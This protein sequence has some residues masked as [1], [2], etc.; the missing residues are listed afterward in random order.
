[1][2][3]L[4]L[5]CAG[6]LTQVA[7]RLPSGQ[8]FEFVEEASQGHGTQA[9]PLIRHAL[10]QAGI[11]LDELK[12]L[13]VGRGPGS[14]NGVRVALTTMKGLAFAL[15]VPLIAA[16]RL[17]ALAASALPALVSRAGESTLSC[18]PLIDAG[19]GQYYWALYEGAE[20]RERHAPTLASMEEIAAALASEP[21]AAS[22]RSGLWLCPLPSGEAEMASDSIAHRLDLES[23][24]E[25]TE[26][27]PAATL[28]LLQGRYRRQGADDPV[29]L[30]AMHLR[31]FDAKLP[32]TPL[33]L[34]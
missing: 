7:L 2:A 29:A 9:L 30:E 11:E 19:R 26:I 13:A 23:R 32:A 25:P 17:E 8:A 24:V 31:A 20:L 5:D 6:S 16:H 15:R 33:R 27:S 10:G 21:A 34:S 14:F 3:A 28:E 1:M 22:L 18:I 12:L 4:F